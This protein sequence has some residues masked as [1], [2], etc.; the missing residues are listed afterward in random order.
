MT[1]LDLETGL[2]EL[3]EDHFFRVSQDV[4]KIIQRTPDTPW[5]DERVFSSTHGKVESRVID[6]EVGSF[7]GPK[8]VQVVQK[9]EVE[10][11]LVVFVT[12]NTREHVMAAVGDP[13]SKHYTPEHRFPASFKDE[14]EVLATA[15]AAVE[16]WEE[17]KFRR[18]LIGDYPPKK[19]VH[20]EKVEED[21]TPSS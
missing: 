2:P 1:N 21:E 8:I 5:M 16:G 15:I 20:E 4:V 7:W 6:R 17:Q 10:R 11:I 19:L 13:K 3:P 12:P 14:A 9:R 18:R